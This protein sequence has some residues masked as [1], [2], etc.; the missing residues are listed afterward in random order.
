MRKDLMIW[1]I[2]LLVLIAI[3]SGAACW[4]G[5]AIPWPAAPAPTPTPIIPIVNIQEIRQAAE[6]ATV[7]YMLSTDVTSTRVPDDIRQ[8]LGVKEEIVLI[9]YGEVAAGFDLSELE[10]GALW[11]DGTRVQL[12]LP[13]PK[14][15]YTR[16]DNERTHV[17]YYQKTWLIEHDPH[18]E[19]E[20]RQQAE[21]II[22]QA[23]LDGEV[24]QQA[25]E[26]GQLFF[27][28]WFYSMGFTEVRIII[29]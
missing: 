13:A 11:T 2:A 6:L 28:N 27:E 23:A 12:H 8:A 7:K 22:R 1:G 9:A 3:V 18:L 5:A 15:L 25:R 19:G 16:L 29:D 20:A 4:I 26:Y 14:L 10:E 17:V 24:L 21:E